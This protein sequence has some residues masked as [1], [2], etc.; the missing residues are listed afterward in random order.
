MGNAQS[1]PKK[2]HKGLPRTAAAAKKHGFKNVKVDFAKLSAPEKKKYIHIAAPNAKS[3]AIALIRPADSHPP[4]HVTPG[5]EPGTYIVCYY[6]PETGRYDKYCHA[7]PAS[8]L[9]A[10]NPR[11]RR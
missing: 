5:A 4:E 8:E 11:G 9:E 1:T 10:I 7:V 6:D 3:N 2:T